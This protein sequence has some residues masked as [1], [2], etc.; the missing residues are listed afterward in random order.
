IDFSQTYLP[1]VNAASLRLLLA[2]SANKG[3][4]V[5]SLDI[6]TAFLNGDID[7]DVYVWQPPGSVDPQHPDKVWK[8]NK[9]LYGLKQCPRLWYMELHEHLLSLGFQRSGHESCL[10]T[11]RDGTGNKLMVAVYVDDDLVIRGS[12]S[13]ST[14][15]HERGSR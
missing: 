11:R 5:D 6:S 15:V 9:A 13:R 14:C 8:L 3:Y 10:Y 4:A 7:G 2:I 12:S 1:V